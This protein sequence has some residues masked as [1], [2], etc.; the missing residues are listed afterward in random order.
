MPR[1]FVFVFGLLRFAPLHP[2]PLEPAP[3]TPLLTPLNPE[4]KLTPC[5]QHI[6]VVWRM[7]VYIRMENAG[8]TRIF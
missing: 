7:W 3:Y 6:A 4:L 1:F 2:K 8:G 5:T